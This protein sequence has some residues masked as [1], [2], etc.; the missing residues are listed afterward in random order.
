MHLKDF[1]QI[2]DKINTQY[3]FGS[4]SSLANLYFLKDV[5]NILCYQKNDILFLLQIKLTEQK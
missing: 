1:E 2:K 4:D 5:L 3:L